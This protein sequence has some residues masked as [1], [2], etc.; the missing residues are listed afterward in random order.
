MQGYGKVYSAD[1]AEGVSETVFMIA[2]VSKVFAGAA[3]SALLDHGL[4]Y[5]DDGIWNVLPDGWEDSACR[6][7]NSPDPPVTWRMIVTHRSSLRGDIPSF[8]RGGDY[9]E[10]SYGPEGGYID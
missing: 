5:L 10:A 8:A 7:R 4:S 2:S 3:V 1:D 6:N 9:I